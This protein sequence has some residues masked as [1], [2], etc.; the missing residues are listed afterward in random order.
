MKKILLLLIGILILIS[1][2]ICYVCYDGPYKGRVADS[3]TGEPIEGAVVLAVWRTNYPTGAGGISKYNDAQE[4]VTDK[5]GAFKL[6]GKGFMVLSTVE[7]S[8]ISFFKAGYSFYDTSNW[9]NI[10]RYYW[11]D[12]RA[13][14]PLKKWT[15]KERRRQDTPYLP[16]E[17][18]KEG[19]VK[20]LINEIKKDRKERGLKVKN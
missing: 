20:L 5:D 15:M 7:L 9:K 14:I 8:S 16:T 13:F 17:A 19:K 11:K 4:T 3:E 6:Q 10:K 12:G 1:G 2:C 18:I